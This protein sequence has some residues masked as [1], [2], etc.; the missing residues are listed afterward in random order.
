MSQRF[1]STLFFISFPFFQIRNRFKSF[2]VCMGFCEAA[3]QDYNP[4]NAPGASGN[5]LAPPPGGNRA[6]PPPNYGQQQPPMYPGNDRPMY[7]GGGNVN[8]APPPPPAQPASPELGPRPDGE[9]GEEEN[10]YE[11]SPEYAQEPAQNYDPEICRVSLGNLTK[12][13]LS[14]KPQNPTIE[15]FN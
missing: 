13:L 3:R 5:G 4:N 15:Q 12:H 1:N 8:Y 2:E 10:G 9:D 6:P 11:T 14:L 7:N